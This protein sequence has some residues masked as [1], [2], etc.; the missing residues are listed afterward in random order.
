MTRKCVP[1]ELYDRLNRK[2]D[3]LRRIDEETIPLQKTINDLQR[4]IEGQVSEKQIRFLEYLIWQS[5]DDS[6][7]VRQCAIWLLRKS[8]RLS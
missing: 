2:I 6:L 1:D 7:F 5:I 8:S 4:L 3:E